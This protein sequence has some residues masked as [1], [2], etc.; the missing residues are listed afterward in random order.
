MGGADEP[1]S[2]D[3]EEPVSDEYGNDI[4]R[5]GISPDGSFAVVSLHG[6]S[7]EHAESEGLAASGDE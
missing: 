6:S 4:E 1:G 7:D 5:V 3:G 2:K